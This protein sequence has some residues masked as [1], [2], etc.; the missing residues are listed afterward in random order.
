MTRAEELAAKAKALAARQSQQKDT[1]AAPPAARST[2]AP[3]ARP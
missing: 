2:A 1:G 3:L